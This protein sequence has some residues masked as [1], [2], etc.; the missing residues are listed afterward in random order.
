M[1]PALLRQP[2]CSQEPG[3][4][5]NGTNEHYRSFTHVPSPAYLHP[6]KHLA[7]E[8]GL[9]IVS[10]ITGTNERCRSFT[11]VQC[12][13]FTHVASLAHSMVSAPT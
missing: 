12:R 7:P 10:V 2:L 6:R 5:G 4:F 11:H 8:H 1:S 9:R 13:S 3:S